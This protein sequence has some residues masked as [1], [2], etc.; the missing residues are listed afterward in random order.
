M[1]VN[2]EY[3]EALKKASK[4][5]CT[6]PTKPHTEAPPIERPSDGKRFHAPHFVRSSVPKKGKPGDNAQYNNWERGTA[7]EDRPGGTRMPFLDS[8]GDLIGVKPMSEGKHRKGLENLDR[9][10]REAAATTTGDT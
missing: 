1:S 3:L 10:R 7:G 9:M 2:E 8:S 5:H 6:A 4:V